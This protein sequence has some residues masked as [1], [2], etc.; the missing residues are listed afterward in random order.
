VQT[1][2]VPGAIEV[3]VTAP[4]LPAAHLTLRSR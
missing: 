2:P 3:T 4:G 1:L